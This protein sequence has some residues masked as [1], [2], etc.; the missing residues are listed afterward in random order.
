V[1]AGNTA[2]TTFTITCAATTGSVAVTTSTTGSGLP[3]S[4][5]TATV[6]G[7]TSQAIGISQTVTFTNL[8][9]GSHTVALS[10]VPANCTVSGGNSQT[11]T[12]SA[13]GTT[14]VTFSISCTAPP[15]QPVVTAGPDESVVVGAV[16]SLGGASFTDPSHDGP[17]TI[18]ISW[19]DGSS[20]TTFTAASE[21]TITASHSYGGVLAQYTL[22]VTVVDSHGNT[23]SAQ[24]VVSVIL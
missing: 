13:G 3:A 14:Q 24:K 18:T 17:Y 23:G 22:T 5:Y 20:P 12:V 1:T 21:G 4:G 2:Q 15:S 7:S 6:D 10:G 9:A 16:Y 8:P 11:V 19:G